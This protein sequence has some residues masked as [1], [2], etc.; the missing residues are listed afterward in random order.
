MPCIAREVGDTKGG[1]FDIPGDLAREWL[2]LPS[3][4]NGRPNADVLKPWRN[5][6]D[7]TRR[8][9]DKWILDFGWNMTQQEAA[10]YQEPFQYAVAQVQPKRLKSRT[11]RREWWRHERPRPEMWNAF[12]GLKRYIATPRVAK[13]R[14]FVWFD[15]VTCPDSGLIAI[16]RDDDTTFGILHSR[17]HETWAL[18]LGTSLEDRPRYTPTTTFET[19]PFPPGLT[20]DVPAIGSADDFNATAIAEAAKQLDDRRNHWLNPPEWVD[21]VEEPG[22][23]YPKRPVPK[24]ACPVPRTRI[25]SRTRIGYSAVL[26]PARGCGRVSSACES[27]GV[28]T[29]CSTGTYRP[30]LSR[31]A[32]SARGIRHTF[33]RNYPS[34]RVWRT[35]SRQPP[36]GLG[37]SSARF[38][39]PFGDGTTQRA[40][41]L[42]RN[43]R[44]EHTVHRLRVVEYRC[45]V[46]FQHNSHSPVHPGCE[47]VL[48]TL[49]V[50]QVIFGPKVVGCVSGFRCL[51][52]SHV[53]PVSW[54]H[55]R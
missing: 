12:V 21:W 8:P 28:W 7:V 50:V 40:G 48:S 18:R 53:V 6:M 10:L 29:L 22:P 38:R 30:P 46:R 20:L 25:G 35:R 17:F 26:D 32:G 1:A 52:R 2:R 5:G 47:P 39:S 23:G 49:R 34:S 36:S 9:S 14:L 19:Y 42:R 13:H 4:P 54:R 27:D 55:E 43:H 41:R 31:L 16:A 24:E 45:H 44:T 3:N 37:R 15:P 51:V 11:T 33:V